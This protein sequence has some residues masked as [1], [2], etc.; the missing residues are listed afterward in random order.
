MEFGFQGACVEPTF[1]R[2]VVMQTVRVYENPAV[3]LEL[4][5]LGGGAQLGSAGLGESPLLF[6]GPPAERTEENR[7]QVRFPQ[8]DHFTKYPFYH[9]C[10]MWRTLETARVNLP[11]ITHIDKQTQHDSSQNRHVGQD[12][13]ASTL[14]LWGEFGCPRGGTGLPFG[15]VLHVRPAGRIARPFETGTRQNVQLLVCRQKGGEKLASGAEFM[16]VHSRNAF[17][18]Q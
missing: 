18:L 17:G 4:L 16:H 15:H 6:T 13:V 5:A 11:L 14:V 1:A 7:S 9:L 3:T 2:L 10:Y 8:Q 12:V